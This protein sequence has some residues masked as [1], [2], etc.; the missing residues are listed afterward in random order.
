MAVSSVKSESAAALAMAKLRNTR[1]IIGEER[2]VLC[3]F[4]AQQNRRFRHLTSLMLTAPDAEE[5]IQET[6]LA[7]FQHLRRGGPRD[8]LKD[9]LFRVAHNL[10][11]KR[12]CGDRRGSQN[13]S[14]GQLAED[15]VPDQGLNP[16][17][18]FA[19]GQMRERPMAVV[20]ALPEQERQCLTLRAE[21]PHYREIARVLDISLSSVS[22]SLRRASRGSTGRLI[23]TLCNVMRRIFRIRPFCYAQTANSQLAMR[24]RLPITLLPAGRAV[25]AD[26]KLKQ[27]SA[28]LCALIGEHSMQRYRPPV[29]LAPCSWRSWLRCHRSSPDHGFSGYATLL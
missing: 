26:W 25:R 24:R 9:W 6:F 22:V 3:L 1:Q 21:R 28:P 7:L 29:V 10:G 14:G 19:A 4:D 12:R 11:L 23:G 17:D 16:E 2:E 15:L 20:W 8:N 27:Q 13:L 18:Q 5:I